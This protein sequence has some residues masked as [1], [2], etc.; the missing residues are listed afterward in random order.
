MADFVSQCEGFSDLPS[1]SW[2]R[3]LDTVEMFSGQGE[4]TAAMRYLV[5]NLFVV[6]NWL[7]G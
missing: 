6:G 3:S 5:K 4:L 7:A 1:G 2:E